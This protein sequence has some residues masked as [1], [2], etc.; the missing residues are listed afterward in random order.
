MSGS[1]LVAAKNRSLAAVFVGLLFAALLLAPHRAGAEVGLEDTPPIISNGVVSPSTVPYTGDQIRIDVD[2]ADDFG[3]FMAY[4]AVYGP[5]GIVENV[6]LIP[7]KIDESGVGGT[8]SGLFNA[9]P[10]YTASAVSYGVEAQATDTNGG[11]DYELIGGFEVEAQ[12]TPP[13]GNLT[14][15]PDALSFGPVKLG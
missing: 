7:S 2:I 15:Q 12:P 13:A 1:I 9:P 6:M 8:Y 11:T 3:V 4:A 14:V 5:E 10:N